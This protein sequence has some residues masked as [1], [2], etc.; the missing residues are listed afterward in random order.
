MSPNRRAKC[1]ISSELVEDTGDHCTAQDGI[2]AKRQLDALLTLAKG[3]KHR[4]TIDW[5]LSRT[6]SAVESGPSDRHD[7]DRLP[8]S[9]TDQP[10]TPLSP[11][12]PAR[13]ELTGNTSPQRQETISARADSQDGEEGRAS[14]DRFVRVPGG[15]SI[16]DEARSVYSRACPLLLDGTDSDGVLFLEPPRSQSRNSSRSSSCISTGRLSGAESASSRHRSSSTLSQGDCL[17]SACGFLASAFSESHHAKHHDESLSTIDHGLVR[18]L[19]TFFPE[20]ELLSPTASALVGIDHILADRLKEYLSDARSIIFVPLWDVDKSRWISGL[21]TWTH[22]SHFLTGDLDYVRAFVDS[23]VLEISHLNRALTERSKYDLVSSISHELRTP[24]HGMLA[25]S[26]LL[27][28]SVLDPAQ[29]DMVKTIKTCGNTLLDTM[30]HLLDFAKINNLANSRNISPS[31]AAQIEGLNSSFDLATLLQDVVDSLYAGHCSQIDSTEIDRTDPAAGTGDQPYSAYD[32]GEATVMEDVSLVV[33]IEGDRSWKIHSLPG[34]WRRIIMNT[35][36]NALKFTSSG[37]VEVSLAETSTSTKPH[38]AHIKVTDTGGGISKSYL[39]NTMFTPFSQEHVLTEG[40]G[41]GLS[42]THKLVT[43]LGGQIDVS[44]ELGVGTEVNIWLPINV[45]EEEQM[46]RDMSANKHPF[47]PTKEVCL[48]GLNP[49]F[50]TRRDDYRVLDQETKRKLAIRDTVSSALSS[51]SCWKL[52][53]ANNLDHD[54]P[55]DIAV[56]EQSTLEK[57]ATTGRV[58]TRFR[59]I[60]VLRSHGIAD[61]KDIDFEEAVEVA[62]V[63]QP[64]GPRNIIE[65]MQ[66][67]AGAR[68]RICT[69]LPLRPRAVSQM[70]ANSIPASPPVVR[71]SVSNFP[72]HPSP[73]PNDLRVLI[74]DD[75]DVNLKVLSTFMS[76]IGYSYDTAS[77]GL[78]AVEKYK[79]SGYRFDYVFMDISMPIMDGITASRTIR[80]Y[81]DENL[82]ERCTIM[83]VTGVASSDMQQ[84]A[85]EAG[86]DDYL[87]KPLSLRD[88]KR[89]LGVV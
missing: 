49:C 78:I 40:V 79:Q 7:L 60:I 4:R 62:Y 66:R 42:I 85:F 64:F 3:R 24:L 30:N 26:D 20:G 89:I 63:S 44:S 34:A 38:Y 15:P 16:S 50:D 32:E 77:N 71:T 67:V 11:K 56:I 65:A 51:R 2:R 29:H 23:I 52:S 31:N 61:T 13:T 82:W 9:D 21:V 37:V 73:L 41:L 35:V 27:D 28:S 70:M 58:K 6:S 88:L 47:S 12:T 87:V 69:G 36:G 83:A 18:D 5:G 59:A 1:P 45:A 84:Q 14:S 57:L 54:P 76:N 80:E 68:S 25:N 72:R 48:V 43:Y 22:R 75:N 46:D 55:G 19:F 17:L 10:T 74:V 81:E 53:F 33:R 86:M 39:Q 8:V